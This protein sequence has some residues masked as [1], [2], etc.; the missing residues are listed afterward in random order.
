M[1]LLRDGSIYKSFAL[2][3][4]TACSTCEIICELV[5]LLRG[6]HACARHIRRSVHNCAGALNFLSMR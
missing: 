3:L 1:L 5:C 2:S 6:I 4:G